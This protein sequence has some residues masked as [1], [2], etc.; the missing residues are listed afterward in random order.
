MIAAFT[1]PDAALPPPLVGLAFSL[2]GMVAGSF[3]PRP[4]ARAQPHRRHH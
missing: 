3:L 4:L 1:A 2:F